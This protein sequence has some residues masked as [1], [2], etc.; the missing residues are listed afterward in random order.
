LLVKKA[1]E[2]MKRPSHSFF[3]PK[4]KNI[5]PSEDTLVIEAVPISGNPDIAGCKLLKAFEF[6]KKG[7]EENYF[8][9]E[10]AQFDWQ[11]GELARFAYKINKSSIRD[12]GQGKPVNRRGPPLSM[13]K[14]VLEFKKRHSAFYEKDGFIWA[15]DKRRYSDFVSCATA[16]LNDEYLEGKALSFRILNRKK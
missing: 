3:F 15:Q 4:R 13:E 1:G 7:L 9:V 2:F 8:K 11:K 16:L 14:H 12:A 10:K 6:I 5:L